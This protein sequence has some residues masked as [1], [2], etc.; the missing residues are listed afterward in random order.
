MPAAH[1]LPLLRCLGRSTILSDSD[2]I[3]FLFTFDLAGDAA[4][5]AQ[6]DDEERRWKDDNK[7]GEEDEEGWAGEEYWEG[8]DHTKT[9]VATTRRTA[10]TATVTRTMSRTKTNK[11][12]NRNATMTTADDADV[13][14]V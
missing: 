9:R 3:G 2:G 5:N 8:D 6:D 12:T 14:I 7:E 13:R 1:M 11:Q 10:K 4:C